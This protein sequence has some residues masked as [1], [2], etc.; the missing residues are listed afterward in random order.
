LIGVLAR[1]E[2][3]TVVEEFFQLFKTPWELFRPGVAYEVVIATVA[4]LPEVTAKLLVVSGSQPRP[5]DEQLGIKTQGCRTA[6][7]VRN[8]DSVVPIYTGLLTFSGTGDA[9][10]CVT[11][12]SEVAGIKVRRPGCAVIRLGYDLFDEIRALLTE[13]QPVEFAEIPALDL[14]I[15]WLR[16]WI[17]RCGI[18]LVEIP[19]IPAGFKF[20]AC[21]THDI[22]FVGIKRHGLDHSTWGFLLRA[23]VGALGRFLKGRLSINNLARCWRAALSLPFVWAGYARDF[24]EPFA[25][26]LQ[27]ERGLGGTYF[28][29]PF[30]GHAGD[31]VPGNNAARRATAYDVSDIQESAAVLLRNGCEIGV[32]GIDA[33]Q[34]TD[35]GREELAR[36]T[37]I[38]GN[39]SAGIRM[40]WLLADENTVAH[41]E[42]AGYEYDSTSGYNETIGYR[43]GTGQV[44]R[45]LGARKLVELPMHIQD[46]ALF[47]PT[48]LDLPEPEAAERC[49]ALFN[50]A[51][52][53]GGVV[54][55]LWHDRSHGPERFWGDFYVQLIDKLRS[56]RCWFAT[57]TEVVNWFQKRR[58]VTFERS[59]GPGGL[60]LKYSGDPIEPP[61]VVRVYAPIGDHGAAP[62]DESKAPEFVET[63]WAGQS[64]QLL[65]LQSQ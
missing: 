61:L 16:N 63:V 33:W 21:L 8:G 25:W 49:Q 37:G 7:T 22:D 36:V 17:V 60:R 6:R 20:A 30:K 52:R 53:T 39:G 50:H 62:G 44:F 64:V 9:S 5:I 14:H 38:T 58:S 31:N 3:L 10:A 59:E 1:P 47:Y 42:R 40:H 32:H 28:V 13:G 43:A 57:A 2:Q 24:W 12:D 35:K 34:S 27:V 18:R 51:T 15:L 23:T 45:P 65:E 41:L 56:L 46:G 4:E 11:T 29:I 26:Y 48:R 54:T 19:P 55:L